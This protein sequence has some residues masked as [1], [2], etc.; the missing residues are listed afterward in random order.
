MLPAALFL[1]VF[2]AFPTGRLTRLPERVVVIACYAAVLGLQVAKIV[3]GVTPD[4][5]SRSSP[6][7]RP[8]TWS[9]ASS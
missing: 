6:T 7:P 8:P 3:L 4:N 1:H 9:R 2:L 5:C